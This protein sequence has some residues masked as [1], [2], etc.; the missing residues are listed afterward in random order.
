MLVSEEV[1]W[2]TLVHA[3]CRPRRLDD[4]ETRFS[5]QPQSARNDASRGTEDITISNTIPET[6]KR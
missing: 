4:V 2:N 1:L 5:V 3:R 6:S